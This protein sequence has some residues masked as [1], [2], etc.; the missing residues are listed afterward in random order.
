MSCP[1]GSP[2][3]SAFEVKS[4]SGSASDDAML[5]IVVKLSSVEHSTSMR[6]GRSALAH[7]TAES[8]DTS[9]EASPYPYPRTIRSPAEIGSGETAQSCERDRGCRPD[10]P[11]T[12]GQTLLRTYRNRHGQPPR[13]ITTKV[14]RS[15]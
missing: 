5:I 1:G 12:P 15:T 11:L 6:A 9:P 7:T 3:S 10:Q 4:C 14:A 8:V 13:R 2:W